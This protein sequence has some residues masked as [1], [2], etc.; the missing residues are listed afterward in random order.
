MSRPP[1][2]IATL[3][4]EA[5]HPRLDSNL[6]LA[7]AILHDFGKTHELGLGADIALADD[8]RGV[9]LRGLAQ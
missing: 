5:L 7:A 3:A 8:G 1:R 9:H 4:K 6:L 2:S